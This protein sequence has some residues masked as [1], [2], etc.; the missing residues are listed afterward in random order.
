MK[1]N[2]IETPEGN[3]TITNDADDSTLLELVFHKEYA[4]LPQD[5]K[6][7][8]GLMVFR[9]FNVESRVHKPHGRDPLPPR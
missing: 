8:V 6:R 1:I 9:Q 7:G 3:Y 4:K 2:L 5:V